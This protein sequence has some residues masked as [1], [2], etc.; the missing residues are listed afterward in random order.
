MI[1][2]VVSFDFELG[3]GDIDSG[4]WVEKEKAG[5]YREMRNIMYTLTSFFEE[6]GVKS[7]W[8]IVSSML[9]EMS[10]INKYTH[11][12]GPYR[13]KMQCFTE[14]AE[15]SSIFAHDLVTDYFHGKNIDITSHSCT[16]CN[17]NSNLSTDQLYAD[18]DTSITQLSNYF[19]RE[20]S[21]MIFP[22]NRV[23]DISRFFDLGLSGPV[24]ISSKL[25]R[26]MK[27]KLSSIVT[28]REFKVYDSLIFCIGDEVT[29]HSDSILFNWDGSYKTYRKFVLLSQLRNL[30]SRIETDSKNAVVHIWLHPCDLAQDKEL[31]ALFTSY[32]TYLISMRD[33]NRVRFSTMA[34]MHK[35][36]L[37]EPL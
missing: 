37:G 28:L 1:D 23:S 12:G 26:S 16:H 5:V 10:E 36:I 3:W 8:G 34:D 2:V 18:Y 7:T 33:K 21:G 11:L 15:D 4:Q 27:Q 29:L 20:V 6:N 25:N 35:R 14:N 19:N 30:K 22:E 32:V 9:S 31:Y 17:F 24:R 13:K